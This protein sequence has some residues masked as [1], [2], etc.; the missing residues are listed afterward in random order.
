MPKEIPNHLEALAEKAKETQ[1]KIDAV[2]PPKAEKMS[3]GID[4]SEDIF[5]KED[6]E[7]VIE[8][9]KQDGYEH[10]NSK[11]HQK[12]ILMAKR[13]LGEAPKSGA[14]ATVEGETHQY[15]VKYVGKG[16]WLVFKGEALEV[17]DDTGMAEVKEALG[18]DFITVKG[19]MAK[20][21]K[22]QFDA[23]ELNSGNVLTIEGPDGKTYAVYKKKVY[24]ES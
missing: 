24:R 12:E 23:S 4:M 19:N 5:E 8:E 7:R 20:R 6:V 22:L 21:V 18:E 15:K 1:K 3:N 10:V 16:R 2:M 13:A 17:Q 14:V 9:Y 11:K